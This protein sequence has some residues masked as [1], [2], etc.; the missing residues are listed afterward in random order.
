M[1]NDVSKKMAELMR[2]GASMISLSCPQC[3]APLL[4]LKTGEIY[5]AG[6]ERRVV[7][8]KDDKEE[9][10]LLRNLLLDDLDVTI[11]KRIEN[12]QKRIQY[13]VDDKKLYEYVKE[14]LLWLEALEKLRKMPRH[15]K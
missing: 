11:C 7:I 13:E 1:D 12:I 15:I 3:H 14:L 10:L 2:A 6:C 9:S 4:K 5:C 8:V